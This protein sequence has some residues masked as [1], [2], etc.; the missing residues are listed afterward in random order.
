MYKL[1]YIKEQ[2]LLI[3]IIDECCHIRE[4]FDD[5]DD[6]IVNNN[7]C[8]IISDNT[9]INQPFEIFIKNILLKYCVEL[10]N[11]DLI[12]NI[13]NDIPFKFEEHIKKEI[14]DE[15]LSQ[16]N[17]LIFFIKNPS[18][19]QSPP[20]FI[21]L[22]N[23]ILPIALEC[24]SSKNKKPLWNCSIPNNRTIYLFYSK[25]YEATFLFMSYHI[26]TDKERLKLQTLH[27]KIKKICEKFN[28]TSTGFS[29]YPRPM[30]NQSCNFNIDDFDKF[31][32]DTIKY[33]KRY[34]I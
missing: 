29:Y 13:N 31:Y 18:G 4:I 16:N 5:I 30:Y 26:I 17:P 20:D 15:K 6:I 12:D 22:I 1:K 2:E 11:Y 21:V 9:Y 33:I 25:Y 7:E 8:E 23:N 10:Y 24:K 3:N 32:N 19:T 27:N 34:F 14:F 28:S